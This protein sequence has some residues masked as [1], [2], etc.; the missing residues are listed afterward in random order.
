MNSQLTNCV[1]K[2]CKSMTIFRNRNPT[3]SNLFFGPTKLAE[4]KEFEIFSV[5]T[6]DSKLTWAKYISNIQLEQ[7]R[8]LALKK[9]CK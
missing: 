9:G 1:N 4:M 7:E 3:K 2:K 8:R 5:T 6:I